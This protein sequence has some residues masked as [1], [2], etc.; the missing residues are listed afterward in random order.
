MIP[1][2]FVGDGKRDAA[3]IP[4]I[5]RNTLR[6]E[7][8]AVPLQWARLHGE[9]R[10]FSRKLGFAIRA[11]EADRAAG[12]VAVVDRDKDRKHHRL[13]E[14]DAERSRSREAGRSIPIALGEAAPHGEAWLLDDAPAV[15]SA[16]GLD[17][18]V[19]VPNVRTTSNP[20]AALDKIINDSGFDSDS[21]MD[22]LAEIARRLDPARCLHRNDT[23]FGAFV[24]DVRSEFKHFL[25]D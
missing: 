10:G 4:H 18:D 17:E 21:K 15:R 9:G 24:D 22:A 1:I 5:V 2:H 8:A 11:A 25:R 6:I 16:L 19:N 7:I 3:T 13:G 23:G 20:K 14:L 12:L